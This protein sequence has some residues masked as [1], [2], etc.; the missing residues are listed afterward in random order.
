MTIDLPIIAEKENG[1]KQK[2]YRYVTLQTRMWEKLKK[3]QADWFFVENIS[4]I[5]GSYQVNASFFEGITC[6]REMSLWGEIE[7]CTVKCKFNESIEDEIKVVFVPQVIVK[8]MSY[9]QVVELFCRLYEGTAY[10]NLVRETI[11][12]LFG[13]E[14]NDDGNRTLPKEKMLLLIML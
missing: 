4:Q 2:T 9:F 3:E 11:N 6:L 12:R 13:E 1:K 7:D 14:H 5:K 8:S 10:G